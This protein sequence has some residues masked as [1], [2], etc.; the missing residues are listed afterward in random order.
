MKLLHALLIFIGGLLLGAFCIGIVS[1]LP[2]P[3]SEFPV[4]PILIS[5]ALVLRVRPTMFWFLLSAIALTDLYRGAGFGVGILSF[6]V[7]IMIGV[8]VANDLFSHRSLVG[9][10]VIATLTGVLWVVCVSGFTALTHWIHGTSSGL[11][12]ASVAL[13][14][15]IQGGTTAIAV[16]LL[17]TI[18]PRWWR[19]RSPVLV[20]TR[21]I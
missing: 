5:L 11:S 16:G 14:A 8:R 3:Y 20:N 13:S 7:L 19:D 18:L 2:F 9:C 15:A 4:I 12:G 6:V 10:L 1:S 17:Y 21:G